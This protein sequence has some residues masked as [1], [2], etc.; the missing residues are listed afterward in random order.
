MRSL[1]A[2]CGSEKEA[3]AMKRLFLLTTVLLSFFVLRTVYGEDYDDLLGNGMTTWANNGVAV[4]RVP[5]NDDFETKVYSYN[6]KLYK[7]DVLTTSQAIEVNVNNEIIR[8]SYDFEDVMKKEGEGVYKFSVRL[9]E[10]DKENMSEGYFYNE[11]SFN[12]I[13][14]SSKGVSKKVYVS[15]STTD[16]P[17]YWKYIENETRKINLKEEKFYINNWGYIGTEELI[18]SGET[19]LKQ[20][21][22][23]A[24]KPGDEEIEFIFTDGVLYIKSIVLKYKIDENLN[25]EFIAAEEKNPVFGDANNDGQLTSAD[26]ALIFRKSVCENFITP[27]EKRYGEIGKGILNVDGDKTVGVND[28]VCVLEKV[29]DGGKKSE[30]EIYAENERKNWYGYAF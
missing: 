23:T 1:T 10:D 27:I 29:L 13:I 20:Y 24:E 28:A 5:Y 14:K 11:N 30:T 8:A 17:F 7:N 2:L 16:G 12:K 3:Y 26:A 9:A 18:P 15:M 6:L 22:F 25:A 4:W 19:G 21:C